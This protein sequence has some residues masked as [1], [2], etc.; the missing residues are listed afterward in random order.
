MGLRRKPGEGVLHAAGPFAVAS[1]T[2]NRN[3]SGFF[4][5]RQKLFA[6]GVWKVVTGLAIS[7]AGVVTVV[8]GAHT[9]AAPFT[10]IAGAVTVTKGFERT[11]AGVG[12]VYESI[13]G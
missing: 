10:F 9:P 1:A 8:A 11:T 12:E 2:V 13:F 4:T 6:K 3:R 7:T 5:E